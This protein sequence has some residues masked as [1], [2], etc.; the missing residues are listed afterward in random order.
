MNLSSLQM[1][2]KD[3]YVL[4]SFSSYIVCVRA[5][6]HIMYLYTLMCFNAYVYLESIRLYLYIKSC[7]NRAEFTFIE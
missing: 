4:Y 2:K 7:S 6:A 3:Y 5:R 1:T